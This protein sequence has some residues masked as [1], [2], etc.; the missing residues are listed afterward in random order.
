MILTCEECH[1]RYLVPGHAIGAEGRRVRCTSCG[2]EWFV[3]P[4]PEE[5]PETFEEP[6]DIEPIPESVK[7]IEEG[8]DVPVII[9]TSEADLKETDISMWAGYAAAALV[10]LCI[11][12]FLY[13]VRGPFTKIWPASAAIYNIVGIQTPVFGERLIF[14]SL[15]ADVRNGGEEGMNTLE[16]T[17]NVLNLDEQETALPLIM[18][19]LISEDGQV[20]DSWLIETTEKRIAANG[21]FSFH[22]VY[23]DVP[24]SAREVNVRLSIE[25]PEPKRKVVNDGHGAGGEDSDHHIAEGGAGRHDR[26][27]YHDQED[28]HKSNHSDHGDVAPSHDAHDAGQHGGSHH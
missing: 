26:A 15:K 2:H 7:P 24:K 28:G 3:L 22:T 8:A 25:K 12:G 1:A 13:S 27:G 16:I 17:G 5:P 18:A 14:D 11:A 20:I 21:E 23:P 4:E 10:F 19:S 9:E 6:E